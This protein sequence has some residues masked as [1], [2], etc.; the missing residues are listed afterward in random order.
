MNRDATAQT[1]E[2]LAGRGTERDCPQKCGAIGLRPPWPKLAH[3][4]C[5]GHSMGAD[6]V[7][8]RQPNIP[9]LTLVQLIPRLCNPR[10]AVQLAIRLQ[11]RL[12]FGFLFHLLPAQQRNAAKM[13][14]VHAGRFLDP[15]QG[16]PSA[17]WSTGF[18]PWHWTL[19]HIATHCCRGEGLGS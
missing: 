3:Y 8:C 16:T 4:T 11:C 13:C 15:Q 9:S 10:S 14:R 12:C 5:F 17:H 18:L 2:C 1:C 7:D 6:E 19:L